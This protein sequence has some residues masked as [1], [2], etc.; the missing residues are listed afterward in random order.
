[1]NRD[2][3]YVAMVWAGLITDEDVL[4][5]ERQRRAAAAAVERV[6]KGDTK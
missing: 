3:K 2:A 1:M 5:H 6:R 4:N